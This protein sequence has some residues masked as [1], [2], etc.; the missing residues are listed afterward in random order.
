MNRILTTVIVLINCWLAPPSG[1]APAAEL[2]LRSRARLSGPVVRLGDVAEISAADP[3]ILHNLE[4][5]PLLPAPAPGTSRFVSALE[6]QELLASQGLNLGELEI[7]GAQVIEI[8]QVEARAP[9]GT[10]A[11]E[12]LPSTEAVEGELK[13]TIRTLL[14]E[15]TGHKLWRIEL[16]VDKQQLPKIAQLGMPLEVRGL[17]GRPGRQ[18]MVVEGP[19]SEDREI[20]AGEI[21]KIQP[22]VVLRRQ[23]NRGDL[24]GAADVEVRLEDGSVP[25]GCFHETQQVL[26]MEAKRTLK[27]GAM[28]QP[29]VLRAPILVERGETVGVYARTGGISVRTFAIARQ[30]GAMGDL[31]QVETL[32]SKERYIARVVGPQTLEVMATGA[33]AEEL[34][35]LPQQE[36]LQR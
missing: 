3:A 29:N 23:L 11:A 36:K 35:R 16:D 7:S 12:S 10:P 26:G 24:V 33:S 22:V 15:Q 18:N 5:T 2:L 28:L 20:I 17:Q 31:L 25:Q 27:E 4:T 21:F 9:V 1:T 13:E 8:G 30:D 32:E 34:A 6:L 19:Q 14:N